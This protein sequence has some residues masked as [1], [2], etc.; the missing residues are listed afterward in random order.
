VCFSKYMSVPLP[1]FVE[2][3]RVSSYSLALISECKYSQR[4]S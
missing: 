3:A 4:L 2:I 1:L